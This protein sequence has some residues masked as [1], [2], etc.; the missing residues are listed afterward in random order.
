MRCFWSSV[1]HTAKEC[2]LCNYVRNSQDH[3]PFFVCGNNP[4]SKSVIV[5]V[6]LSYSLRFSRK[7]C[8]RSNH[9]SMNRSSQDWCRALTLWLLLEI[10]NLSGW[11]NSYWNIWKNW[12]S[13]HLSSVRVP[14]KCGSWTKRYFCC[15][16][17]VFLS[18][19]ALVTV[20]VEKLVREIELRVVA[21]V[22]N[23]RKFTKD[24][25]LKYYKETQVLY[26]FSS[27]FTCRIVTHVCCLG[28]VQGCGQTRREE[29]ETR[30]KD[31]RHDR[32]AYQGDGPTNLGVSRDSAKEVQGWTWSERRYRLVLFRCV[33]IELVCHLGPS[34]ATDAQRKR[35]SAAVMKTDRKKKPMDG[36]ATENGNLALSSARKWQTVPHSFATVAF[37]LMIFC[38]PLSF[39]SDC[40]IVLKMSLRTIFVAC[41]KC[42]L[43]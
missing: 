6:W 29:S 20:Q 35:A 33:V 15:V 32:H 26:R 7:E 25:R 11:R 38:R 3:G 22:K 24:Q 2:M 13:C 10:S 14:R 12:T 42:A 28:D 23:L 40:S 31:V 16:F 19:C 1:G 37:S 43:Q 21:Q 27:F 34:T 4:W 17:Q 41:R 36:K 30:S 8:G 5:D 9:F 39:W 18:K